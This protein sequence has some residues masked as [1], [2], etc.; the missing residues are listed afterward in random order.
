MA[1]L[2]FERVI[3]QN[4]KTKDLCNYGLLD[5]ENTSEIQ[6][7]YLI[8]LLKY[9]INRN[10]HGDD[11]SMDDEKTSSSERSTVHE[12]FAHFC[13]MQTTVDLSCI[14]RE[15][16]TM[17]NELKEIIF[18]LQI[19]EHNYALNPKIFPNLDK[20]FYIN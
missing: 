11:N 9:Q 2:Y 20:Y 19:G 13:D 3:Q 12:L 6:K 14:E 1:V 10:K 7:D 15:L 17:D 8:P 16:A 5:D 18:P 4:E